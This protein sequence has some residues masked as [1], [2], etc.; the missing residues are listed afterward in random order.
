[1]SKKR[2]AAGTGCSKI[3]RVALMSEILVPVA[4][5]LWVSLARGCLPSAA[6]L[7]VCIYT[8]THLYVSIFFCLYFYILLYME[9]VFR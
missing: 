3:L 5:L 8:N 1:M 7:Y 4:L 9:A 2:E 6:R